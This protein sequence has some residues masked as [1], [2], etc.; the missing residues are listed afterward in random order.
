MLTPR[1]FFFPKIM[2]FHLEIAG[3][4]DFPSRTSQKTYVYRKFRDFGVWKWRENRDSNTKSKIPVRGAR[5]GISRFGGVECLGNDDP[6]TE[7][8]NPERRAR[9]GIP[10]F[11]SM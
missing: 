3:N 4:H 8:Y 7:S 10:R 2:A 11:F 9:L 5:R 6:D 1:I